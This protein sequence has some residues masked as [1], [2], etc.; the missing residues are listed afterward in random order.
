MTKSSPIEN[1][2]IKKK[3]A[4]KRGTE[5]WISRDRTQI[6]DSR[7]LKEFKKDIFLKE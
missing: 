5:C 1:L 3:V 7:N 4:A 2:Q 6:G